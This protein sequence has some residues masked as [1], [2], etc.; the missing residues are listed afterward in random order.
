MNLFGQLIFRIRLWNTGWNPF[1]SPSLA[2]NQE[3]K[4][5]WEMFIKTYEE[6]VAKA[7]QE[8]ADAK[9]S[10]KAGK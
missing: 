6:A 2:A 8:A 4:Q 9:V 10:K 5:V 7:R 1:Y 3:I